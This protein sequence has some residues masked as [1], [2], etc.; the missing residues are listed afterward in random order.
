MSEYFPPALHHAAN[1][2]FCQRALNLL[3][4]WR[5]RAKT[6]Q[7]NRRL[8]RDTFNELFIG[9]WLDLLSPHA[10]ATQSSHWPTVVESSRIAARA[11]P[12]TG[13][14]IALVGAHSCLVRRLPPTCQSQLYAGGL[15]QLFASASSSASSQL[16]YE[17][18]GIRVNGRWRFSSG[19]EDATW[20]ILNAPC[21][22]HPEA[23]HIPRFL[24]LIAAEDVKRFDSWDSCGMAATGSHDIEAFQLLVPHDRVFA[25]HEIVGRQPPKS[26]PDYIDQVPLVPF[27]STSIIGPLLGCAE[28]AHE[29]FVATLNESLASDSRV[30]E[31][32]AHS[33]AQLQS[34][35]L[36][37][38]SL[39]SRLHDAGTHDRV[40]N[41]LQLLD[42]RRDRA[43]LAMQ[44]VKAVQRLVRWLGASSLSAG[45][46]FQRHWY[47]I[48]AIAAH[49]DLAWSDAML[50]SGEAIL[51]RSTPSQT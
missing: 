27:L 9:S 18:D 43:Y 8:T 50:A 36:L 15:R 2:E 4:S 49:R 40:L 24:V 32:V 16:T 51:R 22:K 21:E 30:A 38:S 14:I 47:D 33:A 12:S 37:Y 29:A 31:Q 23:G 13:W 19:I 11:C 35:G 41:A 1:P 39:I 20:L 7:S 26:G 46:P 48:Q 5:E 3:P 28:G 45:H 42:L 17:P 6:A 34:A 25:M 44:C 10:P